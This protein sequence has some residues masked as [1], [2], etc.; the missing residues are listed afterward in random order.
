MPYLVTSVKYPSHIASKVAK[1]YLE[2]LQKFPPDDA[3]GENLV[4][5]AVKLTDEGINILGVTLVKEGKLEEAWNNAV[6]TLAEFID[7]EG[8]ESSLEVWGTV[9]ESLAA[10]GMKLP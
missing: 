1:K 5:S 8:Y 2:V 9:Q 4:P 6:R 3:L 7:I 10:I